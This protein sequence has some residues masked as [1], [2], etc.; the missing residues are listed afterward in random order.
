VAVVQDIYHMKVMSL[1]VVT[2]LGLDCIA[3]EPTDTALASAVQAQ[4]RDEFAHLDACRRYLQARGALGAPP[5]FVQAYVRQMRRLA[6]DP[7]RTLGLAVATVACTSVENVGMAQLAAASQSGAAR[8]VF[9]LMH[10]DEQEHF[11]F[12]A[13]DLAP[14]VARRA[15]LRERHRA[16]LT[17]VGIGQIALFRWWPRHVRHYEACGVDF[18]GFVGDI[19]ADLARVLPALGVPFPRDTFRR[20]ALRAAGRG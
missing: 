19:S 5:A 7:R 3:A 20:L 4:V 17:T 11:R 15:G 16:L 6:A 13:T 2:Q 18:P 14:R 8:A 10:R 12:V 1:E 9:A